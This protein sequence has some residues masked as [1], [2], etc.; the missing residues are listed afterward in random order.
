MNAYLVR[1]I[2]NKELVGIFCC[3]RAEL[4]WLVDECTEPDACEF[5][6]IGSGGIMWEGR[7]P[8]VPFW[9]QSRLSDQEIDDMVEDDNWDNLWPFA[10]EANFSSRWQNPV[11]YGKRYGISRRSVKALT[12]QPLV[13]YNA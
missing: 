7:A 6:S 5:A 10:F 8:R 13:D 2:E 9:E 3:E 12:W 1:L 11:G 4:D